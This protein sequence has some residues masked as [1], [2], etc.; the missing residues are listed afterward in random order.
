VLFNNGETI[1]ASGGIRYPAPMFF[2]GPG[3]TAVRS[4]LPAGEMN[5]NDLMQY[6]IAKNADGNYVPFVDG[7]ADGPDRIV[8]HGTSGQFVALI[9]HRGEAQGYWHAAIAADSS[10]AGLS[11]DQVAV[12]TLDQDPYP[13]FSQ[14]WAG[15]VPTN[16]VWNIPLMPG[17]VTNTTTATADG[18]F[19]G[20]PNTDNYNT[21][22]DVLA[23]LQFPVECMNVYVL[24]AMAQVLSAA[25][26]NYTAIMADGYQAKYNAYKILV[27]NQAKLAWEDLWFSHQ[28]DIWNCFEVHGGANQSI[29][30]G[31]F[32]N[33]GNYYYVEKDPDNFCHNMDT[34]YNLDCAWIVQS[35][36]TYSDPAVNGGS[37]CEKTGINCPVNGQMYF[38]EL[39]LNFAVADPGAAII[40]SLGNYTD[41]SDWLGDSAINSDFGLLGPLEGDVIDGASMTVFTVQA[42]V[43]AMQQVADVGEQAAEEQKKETIMAFI[44]AFLLVVPGIG[45]AVEGI[46]ILAQVSTITRLIDFA[47]NTAL[48]LYGV[49]EDPSSAPMAIASI[50]LGAGTLR[51]RD[52]DAWEDAAKI[53]RKM[54]DAVVGSMGKTVSD[55]MSKVKKLVKECS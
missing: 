18:D 14:I 39:N 47:G 12:S 17:T 53:R 35:V 2:T 54:D 3:S 16:Q 49:V 31:R 10:S 36:I 52:A 48:D 15:G 40:Q 29:G 43:E 25:L 42:A 38:P 44:M 51:D 22:D 30:C 5:P 21:L 11:S 23:D 6:P 34:D 13:W 28:N 24:N 55:G 32:N 19:T 37:N 9:T 4:N 1:M 26:T 46:D 20:C 33:G 27:H 8:F 50:L 41:L 45:E 7:A